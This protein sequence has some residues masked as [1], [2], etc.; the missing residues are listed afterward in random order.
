MEKQMIYSKQKIFCNACGIEILSEF[1]K[2]I[3]RQFKVCSM[4]CLKEIEWRNTLSII[5][6]EYH[7]E[8]NDS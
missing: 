8:P 1:P 5:N 3:G 4:K 7:E 6:Q 2:I